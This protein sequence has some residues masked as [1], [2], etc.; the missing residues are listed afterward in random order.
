[1]AERKSIYHGL[2]TDGHGSDEH[3]LGAHPSPEDPRD[4]PLAQLLAATGPVAAYPTSFLE[5]NTPP[6]TNQGTSPQCVAYSSAYDQNH[7]DRV[8]DGR[9]VN[10]NEP[11]FFTLIG[12]SSAGAYMRTALDRRLHYGYPV[13]GLPD[14]SQATHKLKAYYRVPLDAPSVKA[15]LLAS[16]GN[17][18]VLFIGP[19]YHSW[20]HPLTSGKLPPPDYVVGGHAIWARGWNDSLGVRLHNSWGPLWGLSGDCFLPYAYLDRVWEIWRT[21]DTDVV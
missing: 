8:E 11:R 14:A 15:A 2:T 19:W 10:F 3:G 4:F 13:T 5:P 16:P 18:G 1:M 20:F 17:G 7:M 12:G 9:F 6:V 21:I